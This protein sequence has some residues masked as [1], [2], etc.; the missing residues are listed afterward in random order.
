MKQVNVGLL[1]FGLSGRVFHA[2]IFTSVEGFHLS[3]IF[4]RSTE[5]K[6]H[7]SFLYPEAVIV[8]TID[9]IMDDPNIDLI[10]ISLP[11]T[12]HYEM[13]QRSLIAGKHVVIEKPFT[14]T[15]EE[16]TALIHTSNEEGKLL[17]VYQ[18]RR[19]DGDFMTL[20]KI[21]ESGKLG[22]IK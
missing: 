6:E 20:K 11:N 5:K 21:I 15:T 13:A 10:V 12:L 2:P 19:F 9:A 22:N 4:A 8:D 7:A 16:A 3:K 1:G 14:N 17:S 18:N